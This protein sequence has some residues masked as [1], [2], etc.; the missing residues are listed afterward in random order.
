MEPAPRYPAE[1]PQC[2]VALVTTELREGGAEKCVTQLALRLDPECFDVRVFS[3]APSPP[4]PRDRLWLELQE[5]GVPVHA[6]GL[7]SGWQLPSV[8]SQLVQHWQQWQPD[9]V[10]SFLFHADVIAAHVCRR[11]HLPVHNLGL[12]VAEPSL[13]RGW[14]E[15]LAAQRAHRVVAVSN[16]VADMAQRQWHIPADKIV[17]IP[18]GIDV[19]RFERA[20]P[21]RWDELGVPSDRKVLLI[22][23]RLEPQKGI[24]R[25]VDSFPA[26]FQRH[27]KAHLVLVGEGSQEA[28][29]RQAF[30]DAGMADR[31]SFLGWRNDVPSLMKGARVLLLSSRYEGMP[32]VVLDAMASRLP[33]AGFQV[34]GLP[35]LLLGSGNPWVH[36]DDVTGLL[37]LAGRALEDEDWARRIGTQNHQIVR[38]RFSL[39]GMV[40]RYE[41]LFWDQWQASQKLVRPKEPL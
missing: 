18:N 13:W 40:G 33:I 14:W 30:A 35:E 23:G 32:N 9:I 16:A 24:D 17:V 29:L 22:V 27:P 2:R 1:T 3:L 41:R 36:Q 38:T 15:R 6:L 37:E 5:A 4:P 19:E 10:Q 21:V 12:R 20:E 11:L 7:Q 28:F 26:F 39:E 31:V 34:A 8:V 25:L